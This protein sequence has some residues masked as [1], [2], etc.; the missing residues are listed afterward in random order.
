MTKEQMD[1][2]LKGLDRL[3]LGAD[4][5]DAV[6][7]P[8]SIRSNALLMSAF[9]VLFTRS[10]IQSSLV[11]WDKSKTSSGTHPIDSR[12]WDAPGTMKMAGLCLNLLTTFEML[13]TI[14]K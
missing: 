7:K 11:P 10:R 6:H 9:P 12:T 4:D 3:G 14:A 8:Q 1:S 5:G 13:L 2:L